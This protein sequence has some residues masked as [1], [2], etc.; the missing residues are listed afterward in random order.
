MLSLSPPPPSS[1]KHADNHCWVRENQ[2]GKSSKNFSLSLTPSPLVKSCHVVQSD[3]LG[4][5][6][7]LKDCVD[8][9]CMLIVPVTWTFSEFVLFF[10]FLL[11]NRNTSELSDSKCKESLFN[12][13]LVGFLNR[14]CTS[15]Y[16]QW[17]LTLFCTASPGRGYPCSAWPASQDQV[18][19]CNMCGCVS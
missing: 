3:P 17:K 12:C 14:F 13:C 19:Y 8:I 7:V 18:T 4:G 5:L 15:F 16:K 11:N 9:W 10:C 1:G 6:G 2:L